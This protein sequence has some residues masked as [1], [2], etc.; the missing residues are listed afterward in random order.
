MA[1]DVQIERALATVAGTLND[2]RLE[3]LDAQA[4]QEIVAASLAGEPELTVDDGGG[5]HDETGARIGAIRRTD[6]GEWIA[7][8][9]NPAAER[10]QTAIPS[11]P[12][13]GKLR[14]AVTK[15]KVGSS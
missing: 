5:L 15:L 14:R 4:V 6:S 11:P 10:S 9:Q 13:Q 12:P 7:D 1:T 8:R 3:R 2:H